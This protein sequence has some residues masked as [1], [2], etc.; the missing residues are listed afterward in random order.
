MPI[1]RVSFK[2]LRR[3]PPF[4]PISAKKIGFLVTPYIPLDNYMSC[5]GAA[6]LDI[7]GNEAV[8]W[9]YTWVG[10]LMFDLCKNA[11]NAFVR[12]GVALLF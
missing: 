3:L 2:K 11:K 8:C 9:G 5:W 6:P 7:C 10:P 4:L 1:Q 12:W